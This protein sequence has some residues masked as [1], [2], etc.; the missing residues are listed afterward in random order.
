M[1][2][3]INYEEEVIVGSMSGVM[4]LST[5]ILTYLSISKQ[6]NIV[7]LYYALLLFK[8]SLIP[9]VTDLIFTIYSWKVFDEGKYLRL[10]ISL[11]FIL[12][13]FAMV[14]YAILYIHKNHHLIQEHYMF[15]MGRKTIK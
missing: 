13:V 3:Y 7:M 1:I 12:C 9:L 5:A 8:F 4:V 2:N 14:A 10:S 11:F 15:T 6:S